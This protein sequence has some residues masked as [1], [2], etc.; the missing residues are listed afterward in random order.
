MIPRASEEAEEANERGNT[1]V[2]HDFDAPCI[3]DRHIDVHGRQRDVEPCTR[4]PASWQNLGRGAIEGQRAGCRNWSR[5]L[6]DPRILVKEATAGAGA[7]TERKCG[8]GTTISTMSDMGTRGFS[9]LGQGARRG[10]RGWGGGAISSNRADFVGASYPCK[11]T[12]CM[13]EVLRNRV[14]SYPRA[15]AA[16]IGSAPKC[17]RG[18]AP[19]QARGP[20]A[21][22]RVRGPWAS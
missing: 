22:W 1:A 8:S 10:L 11:R 3:V 6:G 5:P 15:S 12:A 7:R 4:A 17:R 14:I 2:A 21:G 20:V 19:G 9:M 13:M 16:A 18:R